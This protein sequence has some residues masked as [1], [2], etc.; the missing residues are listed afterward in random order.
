MRFVISWV[1]RKEAVA[2]GSSL[3]EI[4]EEVSSDNPYIWWLQRDFDMFKCN[5]FDTGQEIII[6]VNV[7]SDLLDTVQETKLLVN[8]W[9]DEIVALPVANLVINYIATSGVGSQSNFVIEFFPSCLGR[10]PLP[11]V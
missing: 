5:F 10:Y 11:V 3:G 1:S 8:V 4:F 9:R 6:P 2:K 7:D